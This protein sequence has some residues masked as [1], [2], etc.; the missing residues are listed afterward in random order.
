[1][2][3][4]VPV[5]RRSGVG[6]LRFAWRVVVWTVLLGFVLVLVAAVLLPRVAGATP[7]TVLTGSMQPDYPPGTL[8]VVTPV[9]IDDVAVGDVI[10]YQLESGEAAVVTH[11]VISVGASLD[12]SGE[13]V[14]RTQGDANDAPDQNPVQEV[15]VRGRLWYAIPYLGHVTTR[16]DGSTRQVVTTVAVG[17]LLA[18]AAWMFGSTIYDRRHRERERRGGAH[19][20]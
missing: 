6:A 11:R 17:G 13:R 16:I 10:T 7:Y 4:P 18:Y 14:L 20:A 3:A 5:Q 19:A 9:D 15:Q 8:V 12:G 2:T 1:M